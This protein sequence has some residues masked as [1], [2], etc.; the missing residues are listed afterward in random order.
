MLHLQS[1]VSNLVV[2]TLKGVSLGPQPCK[3]EAGQKEPSLGIAA[4]RD[5]MSAMLGGPI[6]QVLWKASFPPLFCLLLG[7]SG[8]QSFDKET[9]G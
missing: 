3:A 5:Y 2:R 9:E 8:S 4:V 7:S 6:S 1:L